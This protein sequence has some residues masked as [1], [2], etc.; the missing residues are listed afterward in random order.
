[1]SLRITRGMV[2]LLESKRG[3]FVW[4]DRCRVELCDGQRRIRYR[5]LTGSAS[6][7]EAGLTIVGEVEGDIGGTV[8]E[9]C[10]PSRLPRRSASGGAARRKLPISAA[11]ERAA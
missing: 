1:M 3:C 6:S 2:Q 4:F 11:D 9:E 8:K 7:D 10:A 5:L